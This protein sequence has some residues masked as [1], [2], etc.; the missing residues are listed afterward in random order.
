MIAA[1]ALAAALAVAAAPAPSGKKF[2]G[3]R[4]RPARVEPAGRQ[5]GQ[6]AVVSVTVQR[7]YLDRGAEDGLVVGQKVQLFRGARSAAS[8]EIES[9]GPHVATCL[10]GAIRIGDRFVLARKGTALA[11]RAPAPPASPQQLNTQR[12][13]LEESEVA[14]VEFTGGKAFGRAGVSAE[15]GLVHTSVAGLSTPGSAFHQE[16]LDLAVYGQQ[17]LGGL[18]FGADASAIVWSRRPAGFRSPHNA[19]AQLQVRELWAAWQFKN[20]LQI[21]LGRLTPRRAP[22]LGILDGGLIGWT[23]PSGAF[24]LGAFGGALPSPVTLTPLGGPYTAGA[25]LAARLGG[26]TVKAVAFEPSIR[27]AWV[28]RPATNRFETQAL[29][30]LWWGTLFDA[31]LEA[32]AGFGDGQSS[33]RLDA[34]RF[35]AGAR[36]AQLVRVRVAARYSGG[37][38]PWLGTAPIL[39]SQSLHGDAVVSLELPAGLLLSAQ[40]GGLYDFTTRLAQGRVGPEL[41]LP[42]F[43]GGSL[44]F[45]LGYD[46]EF[47]WLPGRSGY[48]QAVVR[49][50]S[51]MSLWARAS[52][53]HHTLVRGAEGVSGLDGA[54]SLAVDV[55]VWRWFWVRGSGWARM[56]LTGDP[57]PAAL[58]G[59][60]GVGATF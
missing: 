56:G 40:G 25:Y 54:L 43:A 46:E 36:I 29:M 55:R 27:L 53:F 42:P 35:D 34:V 32:A 4:L 18:S 30:K 33:T 49:P 22:G 19:A 51:R 13:Q 8:C 1:F 12:L 3:V 31:R 15:V 14:L 23:S 9:V 59:Q 5:A 16:R 58:Q 45:A 37:G 24:A 41:E 11:P 26:E 39:P 38:D 2:G 50:F 21:G 52:V 57:V 47:G 48:V 6:G 44:V 28:G 20:G 17:L 7:A 60:L 10:P